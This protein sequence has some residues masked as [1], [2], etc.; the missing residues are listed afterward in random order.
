[1]TN[2]EK[3]PQIL[4]ILPPHA[5]PNEPSEQR[6]AIRSALESHPVSLQIDN[7]AMDFYQRVLIGG[8]HFLAQQFN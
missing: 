3:K 4:F 5:I 1:M 7:A 2:I 6:S 8:D